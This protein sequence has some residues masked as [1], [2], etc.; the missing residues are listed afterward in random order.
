M[1]GTLFQE[2]L[3]SQDQLHQEVAAL[4]Q[5]YGL[6][7]VTERLHAIG[8]QPVAETPEKPTPVTRT[9]DMSKEAMPWAGF[10]TIIQA[11]QLAQYFAHDWAQEVEDWRYNVSPKEYY[12]EEVLTEIQ[13][14]MWMA[15]QNYCK[16]G[17]VKCRKSNL[18]AI[19]LL[20]AVMASQFH[21]SY[22]K[23]TTACILNRICTLGYASKYLCYEIFGEQPND[24]MVGSK[25]RRDALRIILDRMKEFTDA[26]V[27]EPVEGKQYPEPRAHAT[28]QKLCDAW[29]KV[30]NDDD[31]PF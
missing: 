28:K 19:C 15:K 25:K 9:R 3:E 18:R 27:I 23:L 13:H 2:G 17:E 11:V 10:E 26:G 7:A 31:L 12:R 30:C 22:Y 1:N 16:L 24:L 20:R 5:Q 6:P 14:R 21:H 8:A 4:L 29:Q